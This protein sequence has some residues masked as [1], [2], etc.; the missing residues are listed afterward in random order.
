MTEGNAAMSAQ[1]KNHHVLDELLARTVGPVPEPSAA[2]EHP[3][4]TPGPAREQSP[5][6]GSSGDASTP[7]NA[8]PV[9]W[10]DGNRGRPRDPIPGRGPLALH[11]SRAA[12]EERLTASEAS[13][14]QAHKDLAERDRRLAHAAMSLTQAAEEVSKA[15]EQVQVLNGRLLASERSERQ[16]EDERARAHAS[17]E[18]LEA[19]LTVMH[20]RE[21]ELRDDLEAERLAHR[22]SQAD[23]E[24]LRGSLE[25]LRPLV[26]VLGR[27]ASEL[28]GA[29]GQRWAA[30]TERDV[31]DHDPAERD[32]IDA[33]PWPHAAATEAPP[34]TTSDA[35]LNGTPNG[36]DHQS[37]FGAWAAEQAEAGLVR[38]LA[39]AVERWRTHSSGS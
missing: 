28:R 15:K 39:D 27:A 21:R 31:R 24:R 29:L 20:A 7:G 33:P 38:A 3:P 14:E 16:V 25:A 35:R 19:Q 22:Q 26:G 23:N 8:T 34:S 5:G 4:L 11:L 32:R 12:T 2:V 9:G 10:R 1:P 13:L 37:G 36:A 18:T 17:R 6:A 30:D